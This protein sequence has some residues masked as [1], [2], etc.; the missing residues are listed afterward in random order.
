MNPSGFAP[1]SGVLTPSFI[2]ERLIQFGSDL[3]ATVGQL[4]SAD[5]DLREK[6]A[7]HSEAYARA[8]IRAEGAMDA[9]KQIAILETARAALEAEIADA[10][11]QHLR[12]RLDAIKVQ[13]DIGRTLSATV[14]A[15]VSLAKS[16]AET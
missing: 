3:H 13:I 12:R 16:G 6:R 4:E 11:V 5:R 8:F 14:R 1:M 7:A 10:V 2:A 9:R 15:E